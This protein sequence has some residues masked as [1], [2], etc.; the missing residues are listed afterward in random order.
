MS[1]A[2]PS[3]RKRIGVFVKRDKLSTRS[4]RRYLQSRPAHLKPPCHLRVRRL[5]HESCAEPYSLT[6]E[7]SANRC[8]QLFYDPV[9]LILRSAPRPIVTCARGPHW[10]CLSPLTRP[11]HPTSPLVIPALPLLPF[12]SFHA[13]RSMGKTT[14]ASAAFNGK[15]RDKKAIHGGASLSR[16]RRQGPPPPPALRSLFEASCL[17]Q[18]TTSHQHC[19]PDRTLHSPSP[20]GRQKTRSSAQS[21]DLLDPRESERNEKALKT[22][23]RTASFHRAARASAFCAERRASRR[24]RHELASWSGRGSSAGSISSAASD[25]LLNRSAASSLVSVGDRAA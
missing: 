12:Y 15:G 19:D 18:H 24:A 5:Y 8:L 25:L 21:G 23:V 7:R 11:L 17:A 14:R 13:P 6:L 1:L 22:A 3:R 9:T 20:A 2:E 10:R 16:A 4:L